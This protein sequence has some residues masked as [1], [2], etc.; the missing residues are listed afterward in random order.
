MKTMKKIVAMSLAFALAMS[1]LLVYH[2][3][4]FSGKADSGATATPTSQLIQAVRY[5]ERLP[6]D[7]S[8]N[9]PLYSIIQDNGWG[10]NYVK[11]RDIAFYMD[12]GVEWN[13]AKPN[14][15]RIYTNRHYLEPLN[16]TGPATEEKVAV[17]STM[18]I[19][20]DDVKV[21]VDAY[22]IDNNNYFKIRDLAKAVGFGCSYFPAN[23]NYP[24]RVGLH[25]NYP[26]QDGDF[27]F[28]DANYPTKR[29]INYVEYTPWYDSSSGMHDEPVVNRI[30]NPW[31][32][33]DYSAAY[34]NEATEF[35][36]DWVDVLADGNNLF[37]AIM[38][39]LIDWDE[40]V[41][42]QSGAWVEDRFIEGLNPNYVYP[43]CNDIGTVGTSGFGIQVWGKSFRGIRFEKENLCIIVPELR[44]QAMDIGHV[45]YTRTVAETK[46]QAANI[47]AHMNALSTDREKVTYLANEVCKR[48]TYQ[49]FGDQTLPAVFSTLS[50]GTFWDSNTQCGGVC[51][52][53]YEAFAILAA[54]AG[55]DVTTL[56]GNNHA[57]NTVYLKD[58]GKWV[59]VDCTWGDKYP[60]Y[61]CMDL[62]E[63]ENY[64]ESKGMRLFNA[65]QNAKAAGY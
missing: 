60:K 30:D 28:T 54:T 33:M 34:K 53:Y 36:Q 7:I 50:A 12:F 3:D 63:Y 56:R 24:A 65:A 25:A 57:W 5:G 47:Y 2:T 37:N 21:D 23:N 14:E 27:V 8:E 43:I 29:V 44:E 61:I 15:M 17:K 62:A 45:G 38:Q 46:V 6:M 16:S 1:G 4:R 9:I 64:S 59:V 22:M 19:Y 31:A 20:I 42:D 40:I 35:S 48:I 52:D 49:D 39:L 41:S 13:A 26:Y 32:R 18:D 55:Y 10:A 58:E 51:E 11:L